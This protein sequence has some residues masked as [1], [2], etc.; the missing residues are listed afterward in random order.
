MNAKITMAYTGLTC[1]GC[2]RK[3]IVVVLKGRKWLCYDCMHKM[4]VEKVTFT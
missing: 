4:D 1:D 3:Q 2:G